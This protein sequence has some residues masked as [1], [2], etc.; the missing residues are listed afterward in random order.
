MRRP[1]RLVRPD[2][3][4]LTNIGHDHFKSFA[5]KNEI[6]NEKRKLIDELP[7][8]GVAVLNRDDP[9]VR[10]IGESCNRPIVWIGKD[11]GSTI[12]LIESRSDY[13]ESLTI[14]ARYNNKSYTLTTRLHGNHLASAVLMSV[15]VAIAAR[16]SIDTAIGAVGEVLPEEGRMQLVTT[17]AG[18]TFIR[19]D[20]K[21][22]YWSVKEPIEFLNNAKASRKIAIFG[23]V[24]DYS[25]SAS[26]AYKQLARFACTKAD[27]VIFVGPH[28]LRAL[29]AKKHEKDDGL[30]AFPDIRDAA[31]YLKNELRKGDLVLLKG[32]NKVDHLERLLLNCEEDVTCW[33]GQCR[34]SIFCQNCEKVYA[35]PSSSEL[36]GGLSGTVCKPLKPIDSQD[37]LISTIVIGLGNPGGKYKKTPHN[38]G[39]RVLEMLTDDKGSAWKSEP[40]GEV[41]EVE[42]SGS[43]L[44]LFRP[45]SE[46]N[47]CGREVREF[48]EKQG[49]TH[50]DC[51]L[52]HDDLDLPPGDVKT[53]SNGG[54]GG[55]KGVRS[56]IS[57]LGTADFLRV[58]IG[59]KP[60]Y[61]SLSA[62]E[63][64]LREFDGEM[65]AIVQGACR[66]ACQLIEQS[67]V[68][69]LSRK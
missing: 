14:Q 21:A 52:V 17:R 38:V 53:K 15:G 61:G 67:I 66:Q 16:L 13:P 4:V 18:V 63:Y 45:S 3:G 7:E 36:S 55:H 47:V 41:C 9:Q 37:R 69:R 23:T 31:S 34:L 51:I 46:V 33:T 28:A 11:D 19:D 48:I 40:E 26:E 56:V 27:L 54:D 32:S 6:A 2:I 60:M 43:R 29:K 39:R 58:R 68:E 8:H 57:A 12:Q 59:V 10:R 30:R 35:R 25:R 50:S 5:H 49:C 1:L 44:L 24:S 62:T 42:V 22:P 65:D 20:F 64:V